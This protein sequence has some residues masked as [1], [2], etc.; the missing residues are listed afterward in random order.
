MLSRRGFVSA[1]IGS[2]VASGL[3]LWYAKETFANMQEIGTKNGKSANGKLQVGI[4]GTG[5]RFRSGDLMY[6]LM[7]NP[8]VE[9]VACCDVDAKQLDY[10]CKLISGEVP[11]KRIKDAHGREFFEGEPKQAA[12]KS[13]PK[14]FKDYR[15]L[16]AMKE[17]DAVVIVTPDHWHALP[18]IAAAK[19]KKDIYCEKPLSLTVAEG[20]A[21]LKAARDNKVVFQTGSQQRTELGKFRLACELVRNGRIGKL[22]LIETRINGSPVQGPFKETAVPE[23][24]DWDFWLGQTA[25]VPYVREKCHYTFRWFYEYSGGKLTDWGAHHNDVAQWALGMDQSGPS[26]IQAMGN[27]RSPE[28]GFNCHSDFLVRFQYGKC[29]E[30]AENVP[31]YCTSDSENGVWFEGTK[32]WIFVSRGKLEVSDKKISEE[33]FKDDAIRLGTATQHMKNWLD[34]I[35]SREKPAADV[36]IGH[37]SAT[38]CHL[39][40]IALRFYPGKVLDWNPKEER[41]VGALSEANK[42]LSR[43]MRAPWKLEG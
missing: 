18:A 34:C 8:E 31:V 9:I 7:G 43:E 6:R 21:M 27:V 16:L 29:H 12:K 28:G 36:E 25:K 13:Q 1:S 41:F 39:G 37:R 14:K 32:G 4:I 15:E 26:H 11:S 2:L 40:N 17:V 19:A 3:P 33:P 42:H 23:G 10:T 35:K 30:F 22:K 5:D 20:Q 24:L 38:M